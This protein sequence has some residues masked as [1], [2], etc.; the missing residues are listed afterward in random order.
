L[1]PLGG[2]LEPLDEGPEDREG[3]VDVPGAALLF[4][5]RVGAGCDD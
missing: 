4:G 2:V 3:L 5:S 1:L